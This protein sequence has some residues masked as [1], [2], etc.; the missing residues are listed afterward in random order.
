V[1][2]PARRVSLLTE[3][4]ELGQPDG[5]G[6]AVG[7]WGIRRVSGS[8]IVALYSKYTRALTFEKLYQGLWAPL[9]LGPPTYALCTDVAAIADPA[10]IAALPA[11]PPSGRLLHIAAADW[12]LRRWLLITPSELPERLLARWRKE[13]AA[14]GG[15]SEDAQLAAAPGGGG[16][17][18]GVEGEGGGTIEVVSV[19]LE[20]HTP[21]LPWGFQERGTYFISSVPYLKLKYSA[22]LKT[23][24]YRYPG[25]GGGAPRVGTTNSQKSCV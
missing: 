25:L 17:G 10:G 20:G 15:S 23:P 9:R 24:F 7:N 4:L 13:V 1:P 8:S 18:M 22:L 3:L 11:L 6:L 21:V 19:L 16:S 2:D 5:G 14:G 12:N